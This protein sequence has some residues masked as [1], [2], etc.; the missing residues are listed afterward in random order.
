MRLILI[1]L[2]FIHFLPTGVLGRLGNIFGLVLMLLGNERRK[3]VTTNINLC[4]P[5][6]P[7][8]WQI[9]LRRKHYTSLGRAILDTTILWWSDPSRIK[10]M[11]K[12]E[13][14]NNFQKANEK[15]PVIVL[16]PHFVGAEILGIR[17]SMEQDAISIYSKQKNAIL[18]IH[19][20]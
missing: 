18:W 1:I 11:V 20:I 6:K 19:F 4:F 8:R 10:K 2:W 15:A 3:V 9:N 14:W 5:N 13:G 7:L 17:I 16:A 12:I